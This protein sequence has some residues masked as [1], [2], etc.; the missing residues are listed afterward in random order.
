MNVVRHTSIGVEFRSLWYVLCEQ[1]TQVLQEKLGPI[2]TVLIE[3][4]DRSSS[5]RKLIR[6]R[7]LPPLRDVS[8]R[9]EQGNELRNK[10]CRLMTSSVTQVQMLV[11]EF[12]F[13]LCKHNGDAA[14]ISY[15]FH[16]PLFDWMLLFFLWFQSIV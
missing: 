7:V 15:S 14:L 6:Q 9:P 5:A 3:F 10:L 11:A 16:W 1:A 2:L 12:L 8:H 13:I 4:C